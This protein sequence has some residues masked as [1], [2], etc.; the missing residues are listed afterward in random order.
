VQP[1]FPRVEPRQAIERMRALEVQEAARQ[2]ALLE[3]KTAEAPRTQVPAGAPATT[4]EQPAPAR[5]SI[6]EFAKVD[7]R[8]GQVL[9]AERVKGADKLLKLEVD[10]G[11]EK[12]RSIVAG[13]A[14]A[15]QPEQLIGRK[16]VVVANLE[17]RKLR[18]I[19]SDGM[20]VAATPPGGLPVLIGPWEDVPVGTRLS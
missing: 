1:L 12:P 16:V 13:I 4:Q 15:Y 7:M 18:G 17:P 14:E 10:L 20:V 5:I 6:E 2:K 9:A 11:E 8:V 3:G 19:V